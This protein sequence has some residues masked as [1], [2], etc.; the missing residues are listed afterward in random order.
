MRSFVWAGL[1][2]RHPMTSTAA[3]WEL[4]ATGQP[5]KAHASAEDGVWEAP[6]QE[7]GR[8]GGSNPPGPAH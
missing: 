1:A 7:A 5:G 3:Q 4:R 2:P 6:E 8:E